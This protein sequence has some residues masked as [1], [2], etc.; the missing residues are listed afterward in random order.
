MMWDEQPLDVNLSIPI[1][2]DWT[3]RQEDN[4]RGAFGLLNLLCKDDCEGKDVAS[5]RPRRLDGVK[6]SDLEHSDWVGMEL[7]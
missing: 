1:Q 4:N 6:H 3:L 2:V 5:I 7:Q